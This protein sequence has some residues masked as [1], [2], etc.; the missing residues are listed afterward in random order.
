MVQHKNHDA[1]EVAAKARAAQ[2][3]G[4]KVGLISIAGQGLSVTVADRVE[5]D[6][7]VD[8]ALPKLAL[9]ALY[10][11]GG[12]AEDDG[13][14]CFLA[15]MAVKLVLNAVTTG[16]HI[17]KGKIL[18]NRM[19]DLQVRAVAN[20][21]SF[22]GSRI[23][24]A[25]FSCGVPCAASLG[26]EPQLLP[27]PARAGAPASPPARRRMNWPFRPQ[28]LMAPLPLF[29]SSPLFPLPSPVRLARPLALPFC[30]SRTTNSSTAPSAL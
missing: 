23:A 5:W 13:E 2:A 9:A 24:P 11:A 14:G 16:G 22:R 6:S 1:A 30:R 20:L 26:S 12:V 29:A 15:E 25:R 8:V 3:R 7:V 27:H 19:V 17:I 18:S 4:A 28:S 10:D 21:A